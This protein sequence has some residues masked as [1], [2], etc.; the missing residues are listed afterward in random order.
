MLAGPGA[1][2]MMS[3]SAWSF[4]LPL[5]SD[6]R[7]GRSPAWR[8]AM[9]ARPC[10]LLC[11]LKC[12]LVL[13]P[14]PELQSPASWTWNPNSPF[15]F[16][17]ETLATTRTLS[18][19]CV[20]VVLQRTVLPLVGSSVALALGPSPC[21]LWHAATSGNSAAI[22]TFLIGLLFLSGC[23]RGRRLRV[24]H[25]LVLLVVRDSPVLRVSQLLGILRFRRGGLVRFRG[26]LGIALG[27]RCGE[28]G[29]NAGKRSEHEAGGERDDD[30]LLHGCPPPQCCGWVAPAGLSVAA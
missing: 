1:T 2:E 14:S 3:T 16:N 7:L 18:P 17:P 12:P 5:A 27:R 25:S 6:L 10:G 29:V 8:S 23:S 9:P 26:L 30:C 20:K 15:G 19:C 13:M 22:R 4:A 11:G 24:F 28:L 21:M